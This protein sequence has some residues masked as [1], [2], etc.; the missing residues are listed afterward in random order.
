MRGSRSGGTGKGAILG[1]HEF[2]GDFRNSVE[3]EVVKR[4]GS[5]GEEEMGEGAKL[6]PGLNS[7]TMFDH[8]EISEMGGK[9]ENVRNV[10][11]MADEW[12]WIREVVVRIGNLGWGGDVV[13]RQSEGREWG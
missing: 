3:G 8:A 13:T 9:R 12:K 2:S 4:G 1:I 5:A 7:W 11:V 6:I 10:L